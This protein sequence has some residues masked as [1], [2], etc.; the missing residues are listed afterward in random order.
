MPK[1]G[2]VGSLLRR[3]GLYSSHLNFWRKQRTQGILAGLKTGKRGRKPLLKNPLS[4]KVAQLERENRKLRERLDKAETI[5]EVQKKVSALLAS[6][7][8]EKKD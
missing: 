8:P 7:E 3:E 5:I 1:T 4:E 2:R 6:P